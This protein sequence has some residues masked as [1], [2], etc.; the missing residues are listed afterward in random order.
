ML[1][2]TEET[3]G[4]EI[5]KT[6]TMR[7]IFPESHPSCTEKQLLVKEQIGQLSTPNSLK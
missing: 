1:E 6:F 2:P 4:I 7:M 5:G 3:Y